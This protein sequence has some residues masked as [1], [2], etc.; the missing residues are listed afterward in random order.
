MY[1]EVIKSK[2]IGLLFSIKSKNLTF[3]VCVKI[4]T[5]W[6]WQTFLFGKNKQTS[7]VVKMHFSPSHFTSVLLCVSHIT[8]KQYVEILFKKKTLRVMNFCSK[9]LFCQF[10][11][12]KSVQVTLHNYFTGRWP[13]HSV[14]KKEE[15][16]NVADIPEYVHS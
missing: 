6:L 5:L 1:Y 4:E 9:T 13:E 12:L 7:K 14:K 15:R 8:T 3:L 16:D 2:F 10:V 11:L